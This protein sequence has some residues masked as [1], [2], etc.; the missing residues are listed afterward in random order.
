MRV[1]SLFSG[2]GGMDLGFI[3]AGHE[4]V[5]ANDHDED[6]VQTYQ[7]NIGD[8]VVLK[9]L[10]K[11]DAESIPN[12]DVVI[13][14]FPCQ[15]FSRAN[16]RRTP[17]DERNTLYLQ[18]LRVLRAKRPKYFFAENVP[19]LISMEQGRVIRMIV[20][21]FEECGY[22]VTYELFNTAD[23]GVP[24]TRRRVI[25]L[26]HR[27]DLRQE[28]RCTFPK[29]TH[30][31]NPKGPDLKPWVTISE[32]LSGIP[33]PDDDHELANH[34]C[35]RYK[36]TNRDFTGH[37]RTDPEKPSPTILARG[38]GGGGVCAI[39]HFRNHRRMSVRESAIIQTFPVDYVFHGSL[40]SMYRQVGNA[41]PVFFARQLGE[42]LAAVGTVGQ[43]VEAA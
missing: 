12:G 3:Q 13:G 16:M 11:V 23:F 24:Q 36:I 30:A 35:S 41:V 34:V 28:R 18:F 43:R 42:R 26:G 15:G 14:G 6:A 8:H 21:D 37:R 31:R 9:D 40:N 33:E 38:N 4:V 1:I 25:I 19:G 22:D 17:E 27:K 7:A 5:W 10:E 32:A 29:P 2:A 39:Q 20:N